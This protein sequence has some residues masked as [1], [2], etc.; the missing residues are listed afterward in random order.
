MPAQG[1]RAGEGPGVPV[2]QG[3]P[4]M[5]WEG[6]PAGWRHKA[7]CGEGIQLLEVT[8]SQEGLGYCPVGKGVTP[9]EEC[10]SSWPCW[11]QAGVLGPVGAG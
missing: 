4:C 11:H 3:G 10:W 9:W 8:G 5:G 2:S 1:P 6:H 7:T